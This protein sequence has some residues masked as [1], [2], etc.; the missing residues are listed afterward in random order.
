MID[1]DNFKRINDTYGHDDGDKAIV[2]LSEILRTSTQ[3]QDL[4]ARFGG[5]E[6]CVALLAQ[7]DEVAFEVMERIRKKV[8]EFSFPAHNGEKISF[9]VSIGLCRYEEGEDINEV[10]N[11]ADM[12]LYEAKNSGKNRIVF[13]KD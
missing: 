6:F 5:E 10:I 8:E 3:Q 13:K 12:N 1:I 2:G 11:Q 9:T 7:N 4:V